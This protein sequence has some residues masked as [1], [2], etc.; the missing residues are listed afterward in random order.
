M[1]SLTTLRA[2]THR[3][4][5]TP[6]NQL[7]QIA[8]FLATALGDCAD[9]LSAPQSQNNARSES[10]ASLQVHKLKTR[11]TGLL[12]DRTI[13]GRWTA[14]ILVKATIEAG[15]WEILRGCEPWVR[16]LLS[17]LGKPDPTSTRKLCII[18]LTR[19]FHLTYQYQTLVREI[20][21]PSLPGF[22]TA[23]LNAVSVKPT[24]E[25]TRVLKPN[26]TLLETV[27]HALTDLIARHPTVL[28][29]FS[30]QIH[31]LLTV[32][33]GTTDQSFSEGVTRLAHRLFIS[34]HNCAPKNTHGEEWK[35]ALRL[36]ISSAH[37]AADHTFRA[38]VEQWESADSSL[39][40]VAR[41]HDYSLQAGDYESDSLGLPGWQGL[42]AGADRLTNLLRLLSGFV[43]TRTAA[44]V[45]I[46]LGSL[47]DL[48]SRLA[49]V[50][51]P[52]EGNDASES[53][54]QLNPQIGR[55]ERESLW[56]ELPR[57]HVAC[58]ELFMTV[59]ECLET[60]VVP[61]AHNILE[62]SLWIFETERFN[63]DVRTA[64]YALLC[65]LL[66][67]IGRSMTKQ[68]ISALT[69]LIKG[70][71][72]DLL[73]LDVDLKS[74]QNQQS[75]Q[76]GK[77]KSKQGT[78]N[79]DAFLTTDVKK[80]Q[81]LRDLA[82]IRGL[83]TTASRLMAVLLVCLPAEHVA[84]ALRA[85]IDRTII[86]TQNKKAMIASVLN[87][88]PVVK[89][90]RANPSIMPFL[91]REYG[92]ELE[93]EGLLRPRMPVL[94]GAPE[95]NMSIID[96]EDDE[97]YETTA[98]KYEA[99]R[100]ATETLDRFLPAS[101]NQVAVEAE[102]AQDL[103]NAHSKRTYPGDAMETDNPRPSAATEGDS[104]K[105]MRLE[106][107]NVP[108]LLERTFPTPAASSIVATD[109]GAAATVPVTLSEASATPATAPSVSAPSAPAV[110]NSGVSVPASVSARMEATGPQSGVSA[111]Q[112]DEDSDDELP[113]LNIE[114]DTEDE[115]EDVDMEG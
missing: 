78:L 67:L 10:D 41:P 85:E 102:V 28:R 104:S 93:V 115:E 50:T 84:P 82:S 80:A 65:H 66:P 31:S 33:I 25:P 43:S 112:D 81:Q 13:E 46:P 63:K 114:P 97:E 48:T 71:C 88:V 18:T 75:E 111:A 91:A 1:A 83:H 54:V 38:V 56:S 59:A 30:A 24:S 14:V 9:V 49:S 53:T 100:P 72:H 52:P 62:Q 73:P 109:Q 20:T 47:L 108:T 87:P 27:L 40:Q 15:R 86:L 51:V 103:M 57:I 98:P 110:M 55:D 23:C 29:P 95:K 3:L 19:I 96:G 12:Q 105:K 107:T 2:V 17:I 69:P 58:L 77:S 5:T 42:H 35:A 60:G 76:K 26:P 61:V 94:L 39:R 8:A 16:G 37:R 44:T 21:T 106:S 11:L 7:P 89:G 113:T 68:H 32:V 74:A 90:R 79:A 101:H 64:L 70:S 99:A 34:L 6:V 4:T 22:I 92:A 36:T 45:N